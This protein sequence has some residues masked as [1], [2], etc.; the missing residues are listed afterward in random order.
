MD[1]KIRKGIRMRYGW[2]QEMKSTF[3]N[4]SIQ[5]KECQGVYREHIIYNR[6]HNQPVEE[7]DYNLSPLQEL[8][9]SSIDELDELLNQKYHIILESKLQMEDTVFRSHEGFWGKYAEWYPFPEMD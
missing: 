6:N 7:R 4:V 1:A 2:T 3:R 5:M 9:C 8:M